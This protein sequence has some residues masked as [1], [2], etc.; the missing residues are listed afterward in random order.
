MKKVIFAIITI[1]I[2]ASAVTLTLRFQ[3]D[4]VEKVEK[5]FVYG[6]LRK[7]MV[8]YK[9]YLDGKVKSNKKAT[10]KGYLFHI[11][12]K[13]YP[14]LLPGDGIVIGE[15][16]EFENFDKT[17]KKIDGLEAYI[18]GREEKNEYNRKIIEVE[19]EDGSIEKAYYYEY[20][21]SANC[22]AGDF[23]LNVKSG[24]W[25][26]YMKLRQNALSEENN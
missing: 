8:N 22:N 15:L 18:E 9:P 16:M 14:A 5:V 24:D 25:V 10:F 23:L 6:S 19:L 7:D 1:L 13:G 4:R 2:I 20:N 3:Q 17:L 26:E 12:N 11:K 21:P